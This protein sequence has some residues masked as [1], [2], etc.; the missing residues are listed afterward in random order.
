MAQDKQRLGRNG[1]ALQGEQQ[2]ERDEVDGEMVRRST[3]A[4]KAAAQRRC[5]FGRDFRLH[6]WAARTDGPAGKSAGAK[7]RRY[8]RRALLINQDSPTPGVSAGP[9]ILSAPMPFY[10]SARVSRFCLGSAL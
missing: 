3:A 1:Q 10:G 5:C 7:R 4:A 6:Q 2:T 8:R 9:L